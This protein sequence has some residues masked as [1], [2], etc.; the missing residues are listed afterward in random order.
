MTALIEFAGIT[1][2]LVASILISYL[3]ERLWFEAF[4]RALAP[5]RRGA[6]SPAPKD[7]TRSQGEEV[8]HRG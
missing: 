5:V 1:G 2:V 7:S 3:I 4:F 8:I 6:V